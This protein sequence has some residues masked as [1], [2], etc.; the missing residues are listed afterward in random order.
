VLHFCGRIALGVYVG[1][2][3]QLQRSFQRHRETVAAA[4]L[5]GVAMIFVNSGY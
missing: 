4:Q 3:L 5:Q 2:L 1:N